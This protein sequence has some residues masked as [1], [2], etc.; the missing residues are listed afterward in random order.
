MLEDYAHLPLNEEIEYSTGSIWKSEEETMT[1][2]EEEVLYFVGNTSAMGGCCA[3]YYPPHKYIMI[4]GYLKN[5][6]CKTNDQGLPVSEI[7]PIRD[8]TIRKELLLLFRDKFKIDEVVI[9]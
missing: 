1:Y 6:Q 3:G 9:W 7:E 2:G 5:W 4:P 8:D